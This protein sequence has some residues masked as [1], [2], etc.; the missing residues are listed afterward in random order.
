MNIAMMIITKRIPESN[1]SFIRLCLF[2]IKKPPVKLQFPRRI[3]LFSRILQ[4]GKRKKKE[5]SDYTV[6]AQ[7]RIFTVITSYFLTF[8]IATAIAFFTTFFVRETSGS[9]LRTYIKEIGSGR[10]HII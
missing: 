5:F 1:D 4:L 9:A 8:A 7:L 10:G 6:A 2:G 3:Y